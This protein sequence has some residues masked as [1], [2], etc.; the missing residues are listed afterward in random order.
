M[1]ITQLEHLKKVFRNYLIAIKLRE[2]DV[3]N[4]Y[5]KES[6]YHLLHG[7]YYKSTGEYG[8]L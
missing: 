1:H 8:L 2:C 5:K 6:P 4:V 7:N 3:K